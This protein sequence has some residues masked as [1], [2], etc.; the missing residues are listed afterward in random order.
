MKLLRTFVPTNW[1]LLNELHECEFLIQVSPLEFKLLQEKY[2]NIWKD[3]HKG[4]TTT[5]GYITKAFPIT[6]SFTFININGVRVGFFSSISDI[7]YASAIEEFL[8]VAYGKRNEGKQLLVSDALNFHNVLEHIRNVDGHDDGYG[9]TTDFLRDLT[10]EQCEELARILY[11]DHDWK[12]IKI[13]DPEWDGHDVVGG[14]KREDG[15]YPGILQI[16]YRKDAVSSIARVRYFKD[17]LTNELEIPD[18]LQVYS[19]FKKIGVLK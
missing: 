4:L 3:L 9:I 17:G 7:S 10:P 6:L 2:Q 18:F 12:Y 13:L 1:K 8:K 19:A 14:A 11:P 16:D 5:I 15:T